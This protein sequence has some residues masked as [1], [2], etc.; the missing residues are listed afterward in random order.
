[1]SVTI[2]VEEFK[3]FFDRGQFT[4]GTTAPDVRDKDINEAI[5]EAEAVFN[6]DIYPDETKEKQALYYCTAHFLQTDLN[7]SDGSGG[8]PTF[9]QESRSADGI[10]ESVHIPEWMKKGEIAL[11][12]TT[13]YGIK[14]LTLTKPYMVGAVYSVSGGTNF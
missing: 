13:S 2:T 11:Y 9:N 14:Y 8:Q 10:S 7:M 4:Y 5:A 12:A 3:T 6:H 1:M